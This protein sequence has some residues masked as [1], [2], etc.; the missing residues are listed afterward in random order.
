M[1][2]TCR[3]FFYLS[4]ACVLTFFARPALAQGEGKTLRQVLTEEQVTA[5]AEKLHNLD[6][7]ITS[8]AELSDASQFLIAYYI[9]DPTG[10]LNPPMLIDLYDRRTGQWKSVSIESAAAKWKGLDVDC[11]GSVM[12]VKAFSNSFLLDTHLSPSAGCVLIVSRDL[13][14]RASLCGWVLAELGDN[15]VIYE[16]SQVH[17]APVH[18]AEIAIYDL[19]DKRD[20]T[21]FPPK[22]PTAIRQARIG[23]LREFYKPHE[24]WCRENNDPCD[25]EQFDSEL[26]GRVAADDREKSLAFIISYEQIQIFQG[27][28]K[29]SGP[30]QAVYLYRYVDDEKKMEHREML[31]EESTARFGDVPLEN[32]LQPEVLEKIFKEVPSRKP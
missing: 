13:K 24:K 6:K 27:E 20:I 11:L 22:A 30:K 4:L 10:M 9:H 25:P 16:R 23:Q 31:M 29:P 28:Q 5:D 15:E 14:L 2:P 12:E 26:E 18:P 21:I 1:I 17:F 32:L 7:R 8:G 3:W 19:R